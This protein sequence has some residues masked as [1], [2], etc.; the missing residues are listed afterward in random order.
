MRPTYSIRLCWTKDGRPRTTIH[1]L[2]SLVFRPSSSVITWIQ[3]CDH[4]YFA[5]KLP[6]RRQCALHAVGRA[7]LD[8][9]VGDLALLVD[10][11]VAADDAH[12]G[13]AVVRALAPRAI[14]LGDV[15][16]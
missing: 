3:M 12:V 6:Q 14:R 8:L 4:L 10:H 16:I 15:V 2:P 11:E 13:L 9:R 5:M 7:D 1:G